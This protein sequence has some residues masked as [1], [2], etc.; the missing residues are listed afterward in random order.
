MSVSG[1]SASRVEA[2]DFLVLLVAIP[3]GRLGDRIGRKKMLT[4]ALLGVLVSISE[5]FVV[6]K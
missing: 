5:I 4:I 3:A 2:D 1:G 6:C